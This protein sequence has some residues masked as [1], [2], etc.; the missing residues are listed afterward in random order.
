M[1]R[2]LKMANKEFPETGA[3]PR[4]QPVRPLDPPPLP[5]SPPTATTTPSSS[6]AAS[7]SGPTPLILEGVTPEP[8]ALVARVQ[9]FMEEA[10]EKRS[11]LILG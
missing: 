8:E 9:R 10:A 11:P 4:G 1:Q 5:A 6:S 7:S 3:D 2:L